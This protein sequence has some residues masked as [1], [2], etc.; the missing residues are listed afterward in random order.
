M[1]RITPERIDSISILDYI[2]HA[3]KEQLPKVGL[4]PIVST[5]PIIGKLIVAAKKMVLWATRNHLQALADQSN[6]VF[7]L[8]WAELEATRAEIS[9][10]RERINA[11]ASVTASQRRNPQAEGQED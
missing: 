10:L 2:P 9:D 5:R 6:L 1:A 11:M 8:L 7:A 4:P 3:S